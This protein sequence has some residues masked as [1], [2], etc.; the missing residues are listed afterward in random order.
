MGSGAGDPPSDGLREGGVAVTGACWRVG[1]Q[2]GIDTDALFGESSARPRLVGA[3]W[4]AGV[5]LRRSPAPVHCAGYVLLAQRPPRELSRGK[6]QVSELGL[7]RKARHERHELVARSCC[8]DLP[9][10]TGQIDGVF[11][12]PD[13]IS[14][15]Y[16]QHLRHG[17]ANQSRS[18]MG[19]LTEVIRRQRRDRASSA[20]TDSPGSEATTIRH[21]R[22]PRRRRGRVSLLG[23]A[24]RAAVGFP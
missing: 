1:E 24:R 21:R 6:G 7:A 2:L 5:P 8:R 9:G 20:A 12:F 17:S 22:S 10:T 23:A 13:E 16:P 15:G 11:Q 14:P 3:A 18:W 4:A 19:H